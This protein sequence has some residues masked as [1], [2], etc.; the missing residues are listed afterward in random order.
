M[1]A[2]TS[3]ADF[4]PIDKV[5]LLRRLAMQRRLIAISRK[6]ASIWVGGQQRV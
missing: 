5:G 6:V 1:I 3:R 2:G 4:Q